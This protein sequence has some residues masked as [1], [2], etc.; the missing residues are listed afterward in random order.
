M[1]LV[2]AHALAI[3]VTMTNFSYTLYDKFNKKAI[4]ISIKITIRRHLK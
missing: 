2:I 4:K 1:E 3:I